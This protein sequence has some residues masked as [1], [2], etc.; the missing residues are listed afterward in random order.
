MQTLGRCGDHIFSRSD[1][2]ITNQEYPYFIEQFLNTAARMPR[3]LHGSYQ[4]FS[5]F[6]FL[7]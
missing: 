5:L 6:C 2:G 1:I 3:D 7:E 4:S